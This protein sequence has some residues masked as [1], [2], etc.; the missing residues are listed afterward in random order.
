MRTPWTAS[1]EMRTFWEAS[2]AAVQRRSCFSVASPPARATRSASEGL[3]R[4]TIM[5]WPSATRG[6]GAPASPTQLA[7]ERGAFVPAPPEAAISTA[8]VARAGRPSRAK[9]LR[10]RIERKILRVREVLGEARSG[11]DHR[12]VVGAKVEGREGGFRERR[13]QLGV[14]RHAADDGDPLG[15]RRLRRLERPPDERAHDRP[16]VARGEIGPAALE[17]RGREVAHRVEQRRLEAGEGEVEAGHARDGKVIGAR[18]ALAREAVERGAARIAES[19]QARALVEG[20]AGGV[21]DRRPDAAEAALV[22][23]VE[24]QRVP[25][26]REQAE[27]RR[28]ELIGLEEER[29]DVAVQ[30]VDGRQRQPASERDPLRRRDADEER[31]DQSRAGS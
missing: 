2:A 8:A 19:E 20:L 9:R 18:I 28:L 12:R 22:A 26:A 23:H 21:V 1:L 3:R 27:E 31:P 10:T 15:A 29:R 4:T 7:P 11:G 5:R 16:L 17:L 6:L 25:A 30:V 14:R 13:P 24:E